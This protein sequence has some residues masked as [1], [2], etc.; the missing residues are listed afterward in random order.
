[1]PYK[2]VLRMRGLIRYSFIR[3][4]S[5]VVKLFSSLEGHLTVT[6]CAGIHHAILRNSCGSEIGRAGGGGTCAMLVQRRRGDIRLTHKAY[7]IALRL[8]LR[9]GTDADTDFV[10]IQ[11]I[12]D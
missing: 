6:H 2:A 4:R 7:P 12:V 5:R 9:V 10:G 8:A 1:M 11:C 3:H